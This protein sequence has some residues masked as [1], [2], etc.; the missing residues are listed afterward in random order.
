MIGADD[1]LVKPVDPDEVVARVERFAGAPRRRGQAVPVPEA[2]S[3]DSSNLTPREREV[4][5]LLVG[6]RAQPEIAR[7]LHISSKTA[8]THIQRILAKLGVHSRAQAVAL[9]ARDHLVE[10]GA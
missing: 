7:E 9:A 10:K 3:N 4:L 1:Y 5:A 8:S 6:G 2:R